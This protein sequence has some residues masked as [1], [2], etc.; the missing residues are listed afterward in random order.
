MSFTEGSRRILKL[1]AFLAERDGSPTVH[2]RHVLTAMM[3]DESLGGEILQSFGL[4]LADCLIHW[5]WSEH[6]EIPDLIPNRPNSP[7]LELV[8]DTATGKAFEASRAGELG[9]EHLLWGLVSVESEVTEFL[10]ERD[11]VPET[12]EA[13]IVDLTGVDSSPISVQETLE[14]A[15]LPNRERADAWR[16]LDASLNRCSEGIRVVEDIFRFGRDDGGTS[17][18][19]KQWRHDFAE[20]V[21]QVPSHTRL[22]LRDTPHDVGTNIRTKA[23]F[24]RASIDDLLVANFSRAK[25]ALRSIEE[26]S[27]LLGSVGVNVP[28]LAESLRYRLYT[29][30]KLVMRCVNATER[31]RD[32]RLYLLVS[33][34]LCSPKSPEEVVQA[35]IAN[36]VDVIQLREK[37]LDDREYLAWAREVRKWTQQAGV[38][39]II[40]DRPDIAVLCDADGVHV[41]QEDFSVAEARRIIGPNKLVGVSTHHLE[42][43]HQ[44][45]L[46]GADYLGAGPTFPS[47]TKDFPEG[48]AGEA[49]LQELTSEIEIPHFAI[50]G[51]DQTN[52]DKVLATGCNRV[53][54][55][56]VICKSTEPGAAT[57]TMAGLLR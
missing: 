46:D 15:E 53:A 9:S 10:S 28:A 40:N 37:D 57:K 3:S 44:A 56:G 34:W 27:K 39:L 26:V 16:T 42:Q 35:A 1:A 54:V 51:I 12:I 50:G 19:L 29:I 49:Y 25:E 36:G 24:S 20:L 23:E 17:K 43:A 4:T 6:G 2:P 30:E 52:L 13:K 32:S 18:L 11:V 8:L 47:G 48:F 45:V 7:D 55:C 31:I 21:R 14:L 33:R 22:E 5:N 41:G 38:L